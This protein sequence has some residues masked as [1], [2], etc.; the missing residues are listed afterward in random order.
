MINWELFQPR[1][2]FVVAVISITAYM[3]FNHFSKAGA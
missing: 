1:N 2:L 3:I